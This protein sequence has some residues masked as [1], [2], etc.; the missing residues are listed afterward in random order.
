MNTNKATRKIH[1]AQ[2]VFRVSPDCGGSP[3]VALAYAREA[4]SAGFHVSTWATGSGTDRIHAAAHGWWT[5]NDT[6]G[7]LHLFPTIRPYGWHFSP[8]FK[9][10]FT[11]AA[12]TFDVIH[13]HQIWDYPLLA[14]AKVAQKRQIPIVLTPHGNL[15]PWRLRKKGLK[16]AI[17]LALIGRA[18]LHQAAV[19]HALSD[20]EERC[21]RRIGID[22]RIEVIPNGIWPGCEISPSCEAAAERYWPQLRGKRLT[23]YLA[24]IESEKGLDLLLPAWKQALMPDWVLVIAGSTESKYSRRVKKMVNELGLSDVV[25]FPGL[26]SGEKKAALLRRADLFVLPSRAEGFSMAVLEA[27]AAGLP[28]ML[29]PGCYFPE[30]AKKGAGLEVEC[31]IP[32]LQQ[33]LIKFSTMSRKEMKIMG[34]RGRTLVEQKYSWSN[35]S[36]RI[37]ELYRSLSIRKAQPDYVR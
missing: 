3:F 33:G 34:K 30:A 12:E 7:S 11:A 5:N 24:R 28:V 19:I 17:Y 31:N 1:I 22:N 9:R 25:L 32:S 37:L 6:D 18:L 2:V 36:P 29:T 10:A 8:K 4:R 21:L 23:L 27:M 20:F 26:V 35:C 16:K 13:L 15:D 14:A